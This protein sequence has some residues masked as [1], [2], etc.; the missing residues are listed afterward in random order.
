LFI[1]EITSNENGFHRMESQSHKTE[2]W[3][4]GYA[5]VPEEMVPAI[6]ATFGFCDIEVVDGVV[7]SFTAMEHPAPPLSIEGQIAELKAQLA[8]TDYMVIKCSEAQ[9]VGEEFPYDVVALHAE[10]QEIRNKI[11]ALEVQ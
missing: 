4:D 9:L 1:I 6:D 11:N 5:V 10:R 3:K 2:N 7:V 8:A